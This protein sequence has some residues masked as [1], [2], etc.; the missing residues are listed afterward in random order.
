MACDTVATHHGYRCS[1]AK[2][3]QARGI[4]LHRFGKSPDRVGAAPHPDNKP[5]SRE[6]F[7]QPGRNSQR[8]KFSSGSDA[9]V[10]TE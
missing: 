5:A 6:V 1:G 4:G 7:K 10:I 2:S 8:G 3:L 9:A